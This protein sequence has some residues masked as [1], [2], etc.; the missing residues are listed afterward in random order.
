ME[1]LDTYN[2][3]VKDIYAYFGYTEGWEAYPID[4][5]R[6]YYWRIGRNTVEFWSSRE[7][8]EHGDEEHE[9]SNLI[10][11]RWNGTTTPTKL[12]F[13]AKDYTMIGVD[14]QVDGNCFLRIFDNSK[15]LD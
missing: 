9:F 8:F 11:G 14:T 15:R 2:Q 1:L 13:E 7:A 3:I 5:A 10:I 6:H 4:D 12:V